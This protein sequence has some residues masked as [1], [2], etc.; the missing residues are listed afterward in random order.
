MFQFFNVY[1][2][3]FNIE[4]NIIIIGFREIETVN[5]TERNSH[6]I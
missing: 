2:N 1:N 3:N 4:K 5:L 6:S